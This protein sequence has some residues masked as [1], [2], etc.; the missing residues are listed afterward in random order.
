MLLDL[1]PEDG[2]ARARGRAVAD[3]IESESLD[4]HQRVR[5]TFRALAES[6]PDRYLVLDAAI[7]GR[8][9]RCGAG[10]GRRAARGPAAAAAVAARAAASA[11]HRGR[12]PPSA[13]PDRHDSDSSI[14]PGRRWQRPPPLRF[15]DG[16]WSGVVGQPAAVAELRGAVATPPR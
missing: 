2:L 10:P 12:Q 16:V 13:R 9:R 6:E 3:R 11:G 5:Q 8:D 7:A 4:F 15:A 1:P 14:A